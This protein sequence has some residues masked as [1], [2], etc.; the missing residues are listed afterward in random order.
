MCFT[1]RINS[2]RRKKIY[3]VQRNNRVYPKPPPR[4]FTT[5]EVIACAGCNERFTLSDIKINCA[6]CNQFFHCKVAGT[7]YGKNC[8]TETFHGVKHRE[9]W[10]TDCVPPLPVNK[11]KENREDK[12]VCREC[13]KY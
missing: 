12:C 11:P 8:E 13:Y 2:A 3:R 1:R 7:C 4:T 5:D 9:C 10:C 6:G